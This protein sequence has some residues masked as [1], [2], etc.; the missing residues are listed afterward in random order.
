[1]VG[2]NEWNYRDQNRRVA[3]RPVGVQTICGEKGVEVTNT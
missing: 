3:A 2:A 1:M